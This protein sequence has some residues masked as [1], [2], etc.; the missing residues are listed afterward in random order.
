MLNFAKEHVRTDQDWSANSKKDVQ[1]LA[2]AE[3]AAALQ[4][5]QPC[6]PMQSCIRF[7]QQVEQNQYISG[8][9]DHDHLD[10]LISAGKLILSQVLQA[11]HLLTTDKTWLM[12]APECKI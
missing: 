11:A 8:L 3:L 6:T 12:T 5:V 10:H 4:S 7:C 1:S 2:D 9:P